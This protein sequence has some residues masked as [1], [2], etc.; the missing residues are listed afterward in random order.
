M[1]GGAGAAP[2]RRRDLVAVLAALVAITALAWL[3][4][5]LEASRMD[6]GMSGLS[7]ICFFWASSWAT[8]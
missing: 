5:I 1:T 7:M 2:I 8:T 3:Y 6:M 4:L